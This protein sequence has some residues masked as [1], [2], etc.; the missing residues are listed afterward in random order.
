MF[1]CPEPPEENLPVAFFFLKEVN[2]LNTVLREGMSDSPGDRICQIPSEHED[3]TS[4]VAGFDPSIVVTG[5]GV[6]RDGRLIEWGDIK[7]IS[8]DLS[9]R[10][11]YL[12]KQIEDIIH[13][14]SP[15]LAGVE[16]PPSFSFSRS[17]DKWS[18]KGLNAKDI[19]KCSYAAAVIV[20][21]LGRHG[22]EVDHFDAHRWKLCAGR[23]LGKAEMVMMAR[24]LYPHL[25]NERLSDH[26][27]EAICMASFA[28]R[29]NKFGSNQIRRQDIGY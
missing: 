28:R 3:G 23:N 7:V 22:V 10:L 24:G 26:A 18:R 21:V 2:Y 9:T 15:N 25:R 6:V 16:L 29:S 8:G 14:H 5:Y 17:T 19:I 1:P 20:A 13:G 12:M 11:G 27:A 4:I